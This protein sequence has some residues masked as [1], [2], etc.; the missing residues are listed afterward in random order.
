MNWKH[1]PGNVDVGRL[2]KAL[3]EDTISY[4]P[5][6]RLPIRKEQLSFQWMEFVKFTFNCLLKSV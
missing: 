5:S 3:R 2:R 1:S 4:V 6:V